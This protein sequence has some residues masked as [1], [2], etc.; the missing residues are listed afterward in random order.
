MLR[1]HTPPDIFA[2]IGPYAQAVEAISVNRL[3]F[4][5][6]TM[7]LEPDGRLAKG[8]EAQAHRVW[9]NIEATL[10]AAGMGR[11]NLAKLTIWLANYDDW[12]LGADI[13]Q[14]YLGDHKVAMSVVQVGLVH[15]DWLIEVEAI[16]VG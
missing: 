2:P 1:T 14:R 3:L 5:S 10:A 9:S 8:F 4:I 11:E 12:R 13:R 15:P 6:G 16:A 7:G